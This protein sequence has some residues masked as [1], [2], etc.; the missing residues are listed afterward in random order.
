M[1]SL[2]EL[3]EKYFGSKDLYKV[4]KLSKTASDKEVRKAYHKLS[5]IVHP[6]RVDEKNKLEATEKFKVLG[7]IH[8]ILSDEERRKVYDDTG[9]VGDDDD[10]VDWMAYWRSLFKKIT[11]A[12]IN[13]YED[14][15]KGSQEELEDLKRAYID[16]K[17]CM[18]FI[19]EAVPFTHTGE[20]DRLRE[21]LRP[22]IES[23]ELP[24][25]KEFLDECPKKKAKRHKKYEQEAK[26]A[27][28]L[29]EELNLS[30]NSKSADGDLG[31]IIQAR[32]AQRGA[33]MENFFDKLAEKYAPKAKTARKASTGKKRKKV[34]T[35]TITALI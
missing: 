4:L 30:K 22:L 18:D 34:R 20:E 17:G 19:L 12:D 3:C 27:E 11:I 16:G 28:Q 21:C 2:L 25:Y 31:A 24:H 15:Y 1:A 7:K 26:E 8:S 23:N 32:Q 35:K 33:E 6:D 29:A 9:D 10:C 13:K 5:L 14:S